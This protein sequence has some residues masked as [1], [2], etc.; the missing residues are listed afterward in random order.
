MSA[1]P[2]VEDLTM[3]PADKIHSISS[4]HTATSVKSKKTRVIV[5]V[6]F[7]LL[8]GAIGIYTY[9]I[10]MWDATPQPVVPDHRLPSPS[11]L[12]LPTRN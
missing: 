11:P 6:V 5:A 1:L 2:L 3:E 12:V 9:Q 7:A 4:F 8:L 10:G